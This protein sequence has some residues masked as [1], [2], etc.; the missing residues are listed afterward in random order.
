MLKYS[1]VFELL[2]ERKGVDIVEAEICLDHVH[3]LG[4]IPSNISV[5]SFKGYLKGKIMVMI[6]VNL[7]YRY[8]NRHFL[9]KGYYVDIVGKMQKNSRG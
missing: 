8:G 3:M 5:A 6:F 1:K 2:S 4:K 9:C 7:K